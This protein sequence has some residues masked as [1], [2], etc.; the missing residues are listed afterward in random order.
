MECAVKLLHDVKV[1][2]SK[3]V[4]TKNPAMLRVGVDQARCDP[5]MSLNALESQFLNH[6][7]VSQV[8]DTLANIFF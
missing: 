4:G 7:L 2:G 1:I 6:R 5:R 3:P 8:T